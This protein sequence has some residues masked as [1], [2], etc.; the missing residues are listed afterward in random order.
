MTDDTTREAVAKAIAT[1]LGVDIYEQCP[2]FDGD[3]CDSGTCPGALTEDHD[4]DEHR[5]RIYRMADAAI[6]ALPV[7]EEPA[8]K[9]LPS[10]VVTL[11]VAGREAWEIMDGA[12]PEDAAIINALGN[13]L[14]RFASRVCYDDEGGELPEAHADPCTCALQSGEGKA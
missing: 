11:V 9:A 4:A 13:A 5:E 8:E 1:V 14:E 2:G 7:S 10:D 3:G 12:A 6:G